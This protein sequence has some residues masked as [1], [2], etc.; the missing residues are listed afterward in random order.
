M[1]TKFRNFHLFMRKSPGG[2][3]GRAVL[4]VLLVALSLLAVT[5]QGVIADGALGTPESGDVAWTIY[6][7]DAPKM[8]TNMRDHSLTFDSAGKPHVAYGGE[9]LY[10]AWFDGTNWQKTTVDQSLEVGQYASLALDSFDRPR[11]SYYDSANRSLKFAYLLNNIWYIQTLDSPPVV[12]A[13]TITP[14]EVDDPVNARLL[15]DQPV[16][17][18]SVRNDEAGAAGAVEAISADGDV[19]KYTSIAIGKAPGTG[20]NVVHVS[21]YYYDGTFGMLKYGTWDGVTWNFHVVDREDGPSVESDV[22]LWTSIAVDASNLPG[23]SYMSEKYDDLKYAKRQSSSDITIWRVANVSEALGRKD[24][25]EGVF[26][27]LVIDGANRPHI[28]YLEF[29]MGTKNT[30]LRYATASG[31]EVWGSAVVDQGSQ[32]GFDTSIALNNS[33]NTL[34]VS[35]YDG[36]NGRLK[37]AT[38]SGSGW[39]VNGFSDSFDVGRYTSVAYDPNNRVGISFYSPENG[40]FYYRYWN[41]SSWVASLIDESGNVGKST[42][43]DITKGGFPHIS[44]FNDVGDNLKHATSSGDFWVTST[45]ASTNTVGEFS[46]LKIDAYSKPH[47]A[48]YYRTDG[49]LNYAH[50]NN[51]WLYQGINHSSAD[52]G[53]YVSLVIDNIGR[54]HMSYYDSSSD[55]LMYTTWNGSAWVNQALDQIGDVGKFTS[56]DV[57]SANKPY[58]AY[59]DESNKD[60]KFAYLSPTDVWLYEVV[61]SVGD[62]GTHASLALTQFGQPQITYYDESNGDLKFAYKTGST[63]NFQ[64][65]DSGGDVGMYSS[66]AVDNNQVSHVS[67]YDGTNGDLKYAVR[68]GGIWSPEVV[69]S[70]GDVGQY[71]SLALT[72]SGEP[73]ISYYD[74]TKADLKFAGS[75]TLPTLK[76][77]YL[78]L[79]RK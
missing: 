61:D 45:V 51:G 31:Q 28:S 18:D 72:V 58:I 48:Y 60:L 77:L 17:D 35:Y 54:S 44:Y 49:N 53:Q 63:W 14:E 70:V 56:I 8:F 78:P 2:G 36:G 40:G 4:V 6:Q 15:F 71:S 21:Y 16:W 64:I 67:Y 1:Y 19:G 34:I 46:S 59:Y 50:W 38:T 57:D 75:Y 69:D 37:F 62:V 39:D 13:P 9:H 79:V 47:I 30:K 76:T 23:I 29:F 55:N 52:V 68:Q 25:L 20:Q 41:G 27:S 33:G 7:V 66:L 5:V 22:G 12:T 43:L 65:I 74:K 3:A 11:I 42:S 32:I 10:Y 26:T 24:A 73:G